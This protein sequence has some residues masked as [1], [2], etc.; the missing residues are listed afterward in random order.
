VSPTNIVLSWPTG[1]LVSSTNLAG[2]WDIVGGATSP[3]GLTPS[4]PQRFYRVKVE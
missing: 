1:N 3:Y 2:P 4:E